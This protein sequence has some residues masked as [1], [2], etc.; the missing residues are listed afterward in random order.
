MP[1][2]LTP[3]LFRLFVLG[4]F[5]IHLN[6]CHSG[7][8]AAYYAKRFCD[9]S[10]DF[11]KAAVQL[12]AGTINQTTYNQL[13][14]EHETCMGDEDPLEDLKDDPEAL[15]AFK[16][17]FLIEIKKQCPSIARNMGFEP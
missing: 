17:Q 13:K 2:R 16:G 1:T 12:K 5:L 8:D 14:A 10:S 4:T 9:C 7:P 3:S 11:S 15:Q 6:S